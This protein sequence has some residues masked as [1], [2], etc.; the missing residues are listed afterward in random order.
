[1]G[2]E[3]SSYLSLSEYFS[4]EMI[5]RDPLEV[6]SKSSSMVAVEDGLPGPK[7][8]SIKVGIATNVSTIVV[9]DR[10]GALYLSTQFG[11]A[12]PRS[13]GELPTP[14][15]VLIC[16]PVHFIQSYR[17]AGFHFDGERDFDV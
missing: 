17:R 13:S 10:N 16:Q 12:W 11:R 14:R 7:V 15:S 5:V 9:V 3:R 1:M 6:P 8:M 2:S 4:L